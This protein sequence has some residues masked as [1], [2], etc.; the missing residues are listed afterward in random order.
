M[1]VNENKEERFV[2]ALNALYSRLADEAEAGNFDNVEKLSQAIA[3]VEAAYDAY[4]KTELEAVRVELDESRAEDAHDQI[5]VNNKAEK[6]KLL[7][8]IASVA[9]PVAT[10]AGSMIYNNYQMNKCMAFEAKGEIIGRDAASRAAL[11][12]VDKLLS[13]PRL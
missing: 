8:S 11:K 10:A 13:T 2:E 5:K 3:K 6:A 4:R 9:V 1:V 12:Q 7:V